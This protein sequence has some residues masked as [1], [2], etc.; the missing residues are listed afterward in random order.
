MTVVFYL[1]GVRSGKSS[2]AEQHALKIYNN[3]GSKF[4]LHYVATADPFDKELLSFV[5]K[6]L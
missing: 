1:G 6:I 5:E 2:I 3:L 4:T